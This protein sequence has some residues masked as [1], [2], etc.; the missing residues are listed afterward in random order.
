MEV[1]P[2]KTFQRNNYLTWLRTWQDKQI[3]KVISGVRRCGKSTLF[4]LFRTHLLQTGVEQTQI[5]AL[6]FE[7]LQFEELTDYRR[8][9]DYLDP[10]LLPDK[11]N[12]IFLDEIQHV[13]HYEKA[14]DSLFIKS[15]CDVYITGSNA[16]FMSGELATLLSG[17]YIELQ[18]LPLS[19]R[20]FTLG[21]GDDKKSLSAPEKFNL[22]LEN[23][24]F[25]Y[26]LRYN[27]FGKEA[28]D[29]LRDVYNTI[30]LKDVMQLVPELHDLWVRITPVPHQSIGLVIR[31]DGSHLLC[32]V[33]HRTWPCTVSTRELT[34]LTEL[35]LGLVDPLVRNAQH[36][37]SQHLVHVLALSVGVQL[38]LGTGEVRQPTGLDG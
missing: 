7:D 3:I 9:Y 23:S 14:V 13:T 33:L 15:N 20:E 24:S 12:Y 34:D 38:P 37:G 18:M 21:L 22:Y 27:Q 1:L 19:F 10:L 8:L 28:R 26:V 36:A 25:P 17:R 2:M 30:L 4:D 16:Y 31:E 6:N 29:Y 11:M 35:T 32:E 5:I